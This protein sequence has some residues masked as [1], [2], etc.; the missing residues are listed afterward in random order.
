MRTTQERKGAGLGLILLVLFIAVP[1]VEI[2]VFIKV[3][4]F[5]GLGWTLVLVVATALA[6]TALLRQQGLATLRRAQEN[7]ARSEMPIRELFD[8]ACLLVAGALLLTPGFVTD[9]VG[10][11]L[12]VPSVRD[13]LRRSLARRMLAGS[14][15]M[16]G[17]PGDDGTSWQDRTTQPGGPQRGDIIDGEYEEVHEP[18]EA[19]E[20]PEDSKWG[21]RE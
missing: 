20:P 16:R 5:I 2:A 14:V 21:R 4:G 18:T 11:L 12:L 10:A 13:L 3:G 7:M 6:G 8:G 17:F 1:L 15:H 19:V 9:F